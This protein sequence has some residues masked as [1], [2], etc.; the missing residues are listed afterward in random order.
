MRRKHYDMICAPFRVICI[1]QASDA[2]ITLNVVTSLSRN[3]N[4]EV[5]S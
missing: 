5:R 4:L 2:E 1:W 3:G